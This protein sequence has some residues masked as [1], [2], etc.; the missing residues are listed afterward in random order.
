[1]LGFIV[2]SSVFA[3]PPL[4]LLSLVFEGFDAGRHA[5]QHAHAEAWA[6]LLWQAVGN[7]LFG[8]AAWNWLL[9]RYPAAVISPYALLVPLFGMGSS[10]LL[11]GEPLPAWKIVAAMLVLA[12]LSVITV[13]PFLW[14]PRHSR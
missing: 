3:V 14:K 11:L 7:T 1:M 8:F 13:V 10:S 5:L 12:G 9:T 2:W 6:A 4:I